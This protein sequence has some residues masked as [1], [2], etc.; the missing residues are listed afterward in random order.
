MSEIS[1]NVTVGMLLAD[2]LRAGLTNG[3]P[4]VLP[5]NLLIKPV[6]AF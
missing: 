5:F 3:I 2:S 1:G 4:Q 6:K